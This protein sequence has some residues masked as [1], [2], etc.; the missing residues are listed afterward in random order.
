[1]NASG[2][3]CDARC[4]RDCK[5]EDGG[6]FDPPVGDPDRGCGFDGALDAAA[7]GGDPGHRRVDE[8]DW[9]RIRRDVKSRPTV[10]SSKKVQPTLP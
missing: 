8:P 6:P 9:A 1:M 7:T 2:A 3:D 5:I 4:A 10:Q